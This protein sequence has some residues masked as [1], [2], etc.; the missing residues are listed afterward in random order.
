MVDIDRAAEVIGRHAASE[1]E[2]A[3]GIIRST[4]KP[5][6]MEGFKIGPDSFVNQYIL[7]TPIDGY[8]NPLSYLMLLRLICAN[9]MIGLSKAFRSEVRLG[10]GDVDPMFTVERYLDAYNNEEGYAAMQQRFEAATGSYASIAEC[11]RVYRVLTRL[12]SNKCFHDGKSARIEQLANGYTRQLGGDG[13]SAI[14]NT[15]GLNLQIIRAYTATTG[16][17]CSIYGLTHL[18]ALSRKKME[19]LPA[20]CTVYDLLNLTTEVATHYCS[21]QDGRFLQA[22]VGQMISSEYD[23]EGTKAD[24]PEFQDFFLATDGKALAAGNN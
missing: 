10:K 1:M 17:L 23:L 14:K 4:H 22:E 8:G 7:E 19:R 21:R 5:P 12:A 16:D 11:N 6:H 3:D 9:G 15:D 20:E 24:H 13:A 2:Y 18:D